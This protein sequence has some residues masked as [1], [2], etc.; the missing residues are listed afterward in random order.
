MIRRAELSNPNHLGII[1]VTANYK[2]LGT[3]DI[4][5]VDATAGAVT[6]TLPQVNGAGKNVNLKIKKIDS[7]GNAVTIQPF[8]TSGVTIDGAATV[9]LSS[10]YATTNMVSDGS[11]WQILTVSGAGTFTGGTITGATTVSVSSATALVVGPNGTTNPVLQVV[12]NVGS[13]A[14]GL[15]IT[16]NA[17]GGGVTLTALS[18][19][20]SESIVLRSKGST[21]QVTIRP[22]TDSLNAFQISNTLNLGIAMSVD[23]INQ[24]V[25][26]GGYSPSYTLDINA[27]NNATITAAN[28]QTVITSTNAVALA[29]GANGVTNPVL[30][31]NASTGSQATGLLI[32]GAAT[33]VAVAIIATD[34][35]A[36]TPIT[37]DGKGTGTLG[38]NTLSTTS[39]LVTIG[40]T[41]SLGGLAVN[42]VIRTNG[43][44]TAGGLLTS[45]VQIGASGPLVYS[46]SGAPSIS[47]AV[48]GSLYLR[49]DGSSIS[50]RLY[51]ATDTVGTWTNVA[52]AA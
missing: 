13:Q 7:G 12:T 1:T 21:G 16:G 49:S 34:S 8:E 40:N 45:A 50:T 5:L 24:R 36:N 3:E 33:G 10:Q 19:G 2:V 47:A 32:T 46:G 6:V 27:S 9:S 20:A 52:T 29:I 43:A 31:V 11:N 51:V 23:T 17:A 38:F 15:Q 25:G 42:G 4:I 30:A 39:G 41:T 48:K 26:I 18:S 14:T 44:L 28:I 37:L 22:L 35:G